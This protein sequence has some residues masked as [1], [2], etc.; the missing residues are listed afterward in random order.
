MYVAASDSC[1]IKNMDYMTMMY[2]RQFIR[3]TGLAASVSTRILSTTSTVQIL[4]KI[5]IIRIQN[6]V[7][8]GFGRSRPRYCIF[9]KEINYL[10]GRAVFGPTLHMAGTTKVNQFS[11]E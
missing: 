6:F 8:I 10:C 2:Q 11:L 4:S 9:S 7:T 1:S 5:Q 3:R